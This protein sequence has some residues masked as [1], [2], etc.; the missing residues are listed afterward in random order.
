MG[1]P[2]LALRI[3]ADEHLCTDQADVY[4]LCPATAEQ[5][6]DHPASYAAMNRFQKATRITRLGTN[7]A[8]AS[9]CPRTSLSTHSTESS[10]SSC[11][12]HRGRQPGRQSQNVMPQG[13]SLKA[14]TEIY[15]RSSKPQV[16]G[17]SP[18]WRVSLRPLCRRVNT[19]KT[20]T[21]QGS[22]LFWGPHRSPNVAQASPA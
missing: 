5:P 11:R 19:Y 16:T 4:Q 10:R 20:P 21:G 12:C 2:P 18:V 9:V 8:P 14:F 22:C 17:S 13:P 1:R 3:L 7:P 6:P 15:L